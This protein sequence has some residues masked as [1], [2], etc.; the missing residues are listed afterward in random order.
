MDSA[1]AWALSHLFGEA[2]SLPKRQGSLMSLHDQ[3][4]DKVKKYKQA[5][6]SAPG[7]DPVSWWRKDQAVFS[8]IFYLS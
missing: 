7:G 4:E 5:E 2:S 3:A 6:S 1:G 8:Y